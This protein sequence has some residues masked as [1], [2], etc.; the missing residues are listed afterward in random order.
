MLC[1]GPRRE[2]FFEQ[3]DLRPHD[4]LSVI[5]DRLNA[6]IDRRFDAP[7]L[8]LE[9]DELHRRLLFQSASREC[10]GWL[11]LAGRDASSNH[12][13]TRTPAER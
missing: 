1:A 11:K 4:V 6:A 2:G 7:I 3:A 13:R 5:E 8:A 9:I 12:S 10:R